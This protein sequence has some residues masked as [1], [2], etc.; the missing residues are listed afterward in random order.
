MTPS[1]LQLT[2]RAATDRDMQRIASLIHYEI[3]VHRHLD[4]RPPLEWLGH[5]PYLVA[6]LQGE[7]LAALACPPDPPGVA[8]IR[9][10]ASAAQL[11][12]KRAWQELWPE[13]RE[14]LART[15]AP[16]QVA[17]IPLQGWFRSLVENSEFAFTHRVVLLSW[18]GGALPEASS[19]ADVLIRPMRAQDLPAVERVDWAAFVEIWRNSL[20]S[21]EVAYR[22][23]VDATVAESE[24]NIIAYQISSATATGWHLGRLAVLPQH[25][26]RGIGYAL[27]RDLLLR[28]RQRNMGQMTVNTQHNNLASLALYQKAGFHLTGE[29]YPVFECK[30]P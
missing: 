6:E 25:Q 19:K 14:R 5:Q 22:Q 28:F 10:F 24:G 26:G 2:I 15:A 11:P 7:C 12:P 8:W 23:S 9:L 27:L 1:L 18:A 17:V 13:A 3:H 29:V 4:W 20:A 21:L 16:V 30:I